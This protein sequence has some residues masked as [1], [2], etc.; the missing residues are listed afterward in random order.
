M[1]QQI[2]SLFNRFFRNAEAKKVAASIKL[3]AHGQDVLACV[4]K[5]LSE[6]RITYYVDFGTLLGMMREHDFI[7]HDTDIDIS[8]PQKTDPMDLYNVL[9]AAGFSFARGF[10]YEGQITELTF[11]IHGIDVDF[12]WNFCDDEKQWYYFYGRFDTSLKYPHGSKQ[13]MKCFRCKVENV[14]RDK[15]LGIE[16]FRPTNYS[17]LLEREYGPTW[18]TINAAWAIDQNDP[19]R[20]I[21]PGFAYKFKKMLHKRPAAI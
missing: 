14:V 6:A 10:M 15:F 11:S 2:V 13:A 12:F 3:S 16:T 21:L 18:G 7:K 1:I 20:V 5:A 9:T 4:N 17:Q 19:N 8:V